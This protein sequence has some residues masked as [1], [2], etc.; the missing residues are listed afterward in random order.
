DVACKVHFIDFEGRS[1]GESVKKL[2]EKLQPRKLVI[3]HAT[4]QATKHLADYCVQNKIVEDQVFAP[5]LNESIDATVESR[6]VQ[7]KL[8]EHLMTALKFLKVCFL[9]LVSF[10]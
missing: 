5:Y 3:V 6:I 10:L 4:S 8:S 1:D 7:V 9:N 2:L